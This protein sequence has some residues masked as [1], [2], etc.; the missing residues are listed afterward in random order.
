MKALT[1]LPLLKAAVLMRSVT[2]ADFWSFLHNL[3][4][5]GENRR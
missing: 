3:K 1:L 4:E 2:V 5:F